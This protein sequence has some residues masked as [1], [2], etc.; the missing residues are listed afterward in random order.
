MNLDT[1]TLDYRQLG[2]LY[3]KY[4]EL[5][6]SLQHFKK[7]FPNRKIDHHLSQSLKRIC[8]HLQSI[9][10][11]SS[12]VDMYIKSFYSLFFI[13]DPS[14]AQ[15]MLT[16]QYEIHMESQGFGENSVNTHLQGFKEN[17]LNTQI[18]NPEDFV[19]KMLIVEHDSNS[20]SHRIT[21]VNTEQAVNYILPI[22]KVIIQQEI[23]VPITQLITYGFKQ[24]VNVFSGGLYEMKSEIHQV[25]TT[26][27]ELKEIS[28]RQEKEGKI[29]QKSKVVHRI[30][31][32]LFLVF[33]PFIIVQCINIENILQVIS[34]LWEYLKERVMSM[35]HSI[36]DS[37]W[38]KNQSYMNRIL[39]YSG[40]MCFVAMNF[41]TI[42]QKML[43]LFTAYFLYLLPFIAVV[44]QYHFRSMAIW[45]S[46]C[47]IVLWVVFY[48]WGGK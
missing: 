8:K 1:T 5:F 36:Q 14:Y 31:K 28:L 43:S 7:E 42:L 9:N 3:G 44:L 26:T 22:A 19:D 33:I 47:L 11:L 17:P 38:M 45:L 32:Y 10:C 29:R 23:I 35:I 34:E 21:I 4:A 40:M 20:N 12:E 15:D 27:E 48:I 18:E 16:K 24:V 37:S 39:V 46:I 25:K 2:N 6:F 13:V 30:S 41:S